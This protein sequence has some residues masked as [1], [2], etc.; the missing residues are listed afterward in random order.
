MYC[1]PWIL[2]HLTGS[3]D[4]SAALGDQP[5]T[6]VYLPVLIKRLELKGYTVESLEFNTNPT[7]L[8]LCKSLKEGTYLIGVTGHVV[9]LR[10]G[11]IYHNLQPNGV[12]PRFCR[13]KLSRVTYIGRVSRK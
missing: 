1:V 10:D 11:I 9:L 8:R 13:C 2:Q 3:V 4:L 5:V 7:L 12:E 6:G